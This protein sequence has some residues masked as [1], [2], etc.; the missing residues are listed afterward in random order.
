MTNIIKRG[1]AMYLISSEDLQA[2]GEQIANEVMKQAKDLYDAER[3]ADATIKAKDVTKKYGIS[4]TTLWRWDKAG[5]LKGV[6][7]GGHIRYRM[8]DVE[9]VMKEGTEQ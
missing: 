7:V 5:V 1:A 4:S 2:F 3:N 9:R 8:A 6:K